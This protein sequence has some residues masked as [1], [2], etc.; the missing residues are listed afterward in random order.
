MSVQL[1]RW[2]LD[3]RLVD[4][5]YLTKAKG[6]LAPFGPDGDG[7]Y[8]KD[9]VG[10]VFRAFHTTKESKRENQPL[11]TSSGTV[12]CGAGIPNHSMASHTLKLLRRRSIR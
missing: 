3:G 9:S 12:V 4:P 7:L 5:G 1:G 6:L 10:I 2:N 8:I 11:V